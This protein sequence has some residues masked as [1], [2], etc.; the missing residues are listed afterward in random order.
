M[1]YH[2]ITLI[3]IT[4]AGPEYLLHTISV[5]ITALFNAVTSWLD[6]AG[7]CGQI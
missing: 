1:F 7:M 6:T 2:Q 3:L 5:L 4:L